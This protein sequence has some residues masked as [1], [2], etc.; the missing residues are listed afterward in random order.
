MRSTQLLILLLLIPFL[1]QSQKF[2]TLR[3]EGQTPY[4]WQYMP[5]IDGFSPKIKN[6]SLYPDLTR[7][8]YKDGDMIFTSNLFEAGFIGHLIERVDGLTGD[9]K[10]SNPGI[11]TGFN[12]RE[13]AVIPSF[14]DDRYELF[15]LRDYHNYLW[16]YSSWTRCSIGQRRYDLESGI[17]TDSIFEDTSRADFVPKVIP[18]GI[19]GGYFYY[20]YDGDS[21]VALFGTSKGGT[22]KSVFNLQ[23]EL[24]YK[25]TLVFKDTIPNKLTYI[26]ANKTIG[27]GVNHLVNIV[28]ASDNNSPT[29]Y[30]TFDNDAKQAYL[31][32]FERDLSKEYSIDLTKN[33]PGFG[34]SY[35]ITK[36]T[37]DRFHL[38]IWELPFAWLGIPQK[39]AIWDIDKDGNIREKVTLDSVIPAYL[40]TGL[41]PI[42]GTILICQV[43]NAGKHP[44]LQFAK[45]DGQGHVLPL[46]QFNIKNP[47]TLVIESIN[48]TPD[49]KFLL[50]AGIS[51]KHSADPRL[52]TT[53][54][55]WLLFE[56]DSLGLITAN[57][58]LSKGNTLYLRPNPSTDFIH[59]EGADHFDELLI[60]DMEGKT[61]RH[62]NSNLRDIYIRDLPLGTYFLRFKYKGIYLPQKLKF[63]KI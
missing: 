10:W 44:V 11:Y 35:I 51:P 7:P 6:L 16:G 58:D 53:R 40:Q 39:V 63:I 57:Y 52:D 15:V 48:F 20:E 47:V 17:L 13:M 23:G 19:F 54:N 29:K 27:L 42:D 34:Y 4:I 50:A 36:A 28:F 5:Q 49:N 38:E 18:G 59:L 62:L 12:H 37:D 46:K 61:I 55:L 41:N 26:H 21:A 3:F 31:R 1:C 60:F 8:L 32:F 22:V 45:S 14:R 43:N 2:D 56:P 24:I 25:D 30:D 9:V 33:G